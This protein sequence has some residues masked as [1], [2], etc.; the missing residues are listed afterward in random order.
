MKEAIEDHG[1]Q[2]ARPAELANEMD[3]GT[4]KTGVDLGRE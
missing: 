2:K 1:V 3:G 4:L